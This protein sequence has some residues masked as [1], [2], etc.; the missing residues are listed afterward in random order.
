MSSLQTHPEEG[1]LLRYLD[2]ELPGRKSRQ[3][4]GH[5]EACWQ[6]RSA[7]EELEG[8]VAACVEYRKEVLQGH[9]PPPPTPWADLTAGF[10]RIDSEIAADGWAARLGHWL[11]A[12]R[13]QRWA[14]T[15]AGVGLVAVGV[16]Y[17]VLYT[18]SVQAAT[19]LRRAVAATASA[20][21]APAKPVRM[22]GNF[23]SR[24][25]VATKLRAA[26]YPEGDPLSPKAFEQWRDSVAQKH[27]E[28]AKLS[29]PEIPS[30]NWLLI[31]TTP[32]EGEL[33][34]A[35]LTLRAS[36]LHPVG[37]RFEFRDQEWVEYN[38]F[39]ETPATD[40]GT[41]AVTR[42]E[43]PTRRV[44]PSRPSAL[45][46]GDSA[47]I[48][49]ELRVL[50]ALHEIGADL[51]DPLDITR[52]GGKVLVSGVGIPAG[53]QR[54]IHRALDPLPNVALQFNDP[55]TGAAAQSATGTADVKAETASRSPIQ[56]RLEQQLGSRAAF[57]R[58]SS[59]TLD[60]LDNAMAHAYALRSLAQRFPEGTA[61]S[62]NDRALLVELARTHLKTLSS[63]I[64]ELHRT[65][66]PV[67]V[68]LGGAT[69]QG[70]PA[71]NGRAWQTG[72]EDTFAAARR[73][74]VLLSTLVGATAEAPK[75]H[76][77]SDLQA[78]FGDLRTA[79]EDCQK[80]L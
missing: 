25:G 38:E 10:A 58:F 1:Q 49:E 17:Q 3:V 71:T 45:P 4:R 13:L 31:K 9:L 34:A 53:R 70:H 63:Q 22:R 57:E 33:A 48:S 30:E 29:N 64:N 14:L 21:P 52:S 46:S 65:L 15:A 37:S 27:D 20:T 23:T 41:P 47:S 60:A 73:V 66:A 74:E 39:S 50:A 26:H 80:R 18:P 55:T 43:D 32:V 61:M 51:G 56:T 78:A 6:C 75:A 40:G 7:V 67:L 72:A 28:V 68:S 8:A 42:L 76:V 24:A 19:L 44:V 12:P 59:Q 79:I 77:A 11:A 62:D 35:S 69:A 5:L 2:G 36:D 16:Y 54:E